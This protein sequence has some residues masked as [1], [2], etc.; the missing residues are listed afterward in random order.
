MLKGDDYWSKRMWI[1][2]RPSLVGYFQAQAQVSASPVWALAH[3]GFALSL[4]VAPVLLLCPLFPVLVGHYQYQHMHKEMALVEDLYY[5]LMLKYP[6]I[7][8][9][10]NLP[11]IIIFIFMCMRLLGFVLLGSWLGV[12]WFRTCLY[13]YLLVTALRSYWP[14]L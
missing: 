1:S 14:L 2:P 10:F 8:L 3:L 12:I 11:F 7:C 4:V 13:F 9:S 6:R 5:Y